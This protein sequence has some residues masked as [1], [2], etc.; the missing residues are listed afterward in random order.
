M[1][2][3]VPR[4]HRPNMCVSC[5]GSHG[6]P[7]VGLGR[8]C[9]VSVAPFCPVVDN[10]GLRGF[11]FILGPVVG[12]LVGLGPSPGRRVRVSS[13]WVRNAVS[14]GWVGGVAL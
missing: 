5:S 10:G 13:R 14:L 1:V 2:W 3:L 12:F 8:S 4:G 7:V 11:G 6:G 9:G